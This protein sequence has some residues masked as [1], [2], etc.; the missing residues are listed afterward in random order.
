MSD[1][2]LV[3]V[4]LNA[5]PPPPHLVVR[6]LMDTDSV[7]LRFKSLEEEM[8]NEGGKLLDAWEGFVLVAL[9]SGRLVLVG[10]GKT[11]SMERTEQIG[12]LAFVKETHMR[13]F[14]LGTHEGNMEVWYFGAVETVGSLSSALEERGGGEV[15]EPRRVAC[16]QKHHD[17]AIVG[18]AVTG[19]QSVVSVGE[20]GQI[21]WLKLGNEQ[22]LLLR[23]MQR[24]PI[25]IAAFEDATRI[26]VAVA[27]ANCNEI[28]VASAA[29]P[30][31]TLVNTNWLPLGGHKAQVR[32]CSFSPQGLYLAT[33]SD[34]SS[35]RL[36][37]TKFWDCKF[38][39]VTN[40]DKEPITCVSYASTGPLLSCAATKF[41]VWNATEAAIA[42]RE[43]DRDRV[44][45]VH[46]G[47][48][49]SFLSFSC[50]LFGHFELIDFKARHAVSESSGN[51]GPKPIPLTPPLP[52]GKRAT[53]D[54][55]A[56]EF[57]CRACGADYK[58]RREG[59][60]HVRNKHDWFDRTLVKL[61]IQKKA[62]RH[63]TTCFATFPDSEALAAHRTVCASKTE[64]EVQ[65]FNGPWP[66]KY[67]A[68]VKTLTELSLTS[69]YQEQVVRSNWELVQDMLRDLRQ[70]LAEKDSNQ[71]KF[72]VVVTKKEDR[73]LNGLFVV[74]K[75]LQDRDP[76]W[77]LTHMA[78]PP[79][80]LS[81]ILPVLLRASFDRIAQEIVGSSKTVPR[82]YIL[83]LSSPNSSGN[84]N[85]NNSAKLYDLL[86]S[87]FR[88]TVADEPG[89]STT[90]P[91]AGS[92]RSL[93]FADLPNPPSP[94]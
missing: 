10:H 61:L 45:G 75:V 39:L 83:L 27:Q 2:K 43:Q 70:S 26:I 69:V 9:E 17:K 37:N 67:D 66:E 57:I 52:P 51:T 20:D 23:K 24:Q 89:L 85:N 32:G 77:Y 21:T 54:A 13:C 19:K 30:A 25:Q 29:Q 49:F 80:R 93:V 18:L 31:S 88:W 3:V 41:R 81:A 16:F 76:F 14:V 73:S 11:F 59:Y 40:T 91:S 33:C 34:D 71:P 1:N 44:M 62:E 87:Q 90:S 4:G 78:I 47:K 60:R 48:K 55:G 50:L 94:R 82:L 79:D 86:K 42:E 58:S 84:N 22:R 5:S 7:E 6:N 92:Y 35:I 65:V 72:C 12:A 68:E 64:Y 15:R 8:R 36:Y 38:I 74:E 46:K 53:S 63:C 56:D 28:W